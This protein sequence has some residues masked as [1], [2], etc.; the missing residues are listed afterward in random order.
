VRIRLSLAVVTVSLLLTGAPA[1]A[2][3][4]NGTG[5][6][7]SGVSITNPGAQTS[8]EGQSVQLQIHAS[9]ANGGTLVYAA[10]NLPAGLTISSSSG[11]ISGTAST[12]QQVSTTVTA[13]DTV[14]G[15]SASTSF[16]WLV[17]AGYDV[18]YPQCS[19]TLPAAGVVSIVGVNDGIVYSANPCVA[20]EASWGSG[21]GLQLYANTADPGPAYSSHWPTGQTSPETCDGSNSAACSYDYGWDAAAN[22]FADAP[23][24]DRTTV[25]W[26]FDV[27]TGN[28][29]QTLERKYG[30]TAAS[31]QNDTAA[32]EG[33]VAY[34]RSQQ[35]AQVGFY[36][37]STQW[38][39]ITGGT[40]STFATNPAWLAGYSS[41]S[42]AQAGCAAASFTGGPVTYTQY[43]S[44]S[45]DADYTC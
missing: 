44:G 34:L 40:G 28:S 22:S 37:T 35:V 14:G 39:E 4:H 21:H 38:G 9:D 43:P 45:F 23:V 26:W 5:G 32:L 18:S 27:E 42:G 36:S 24:A 15:T 10:K 8:A 16:T 20:T 25:A 2:A 17:N 29:W 6:H 1:F 13:T 30:N 41:I 19:S 3:G 33:A 11:L 7:H 31:Q 12:P